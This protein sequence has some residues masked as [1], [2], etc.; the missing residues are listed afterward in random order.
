MRNFWW[1]SS[2]LANYIQQMTN[3]QHEW[4][5]LNNGQRAMANDKEEEVR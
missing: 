5:A 4:T 3:K 2:R 1:K